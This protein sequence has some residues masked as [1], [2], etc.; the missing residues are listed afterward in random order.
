MTEPAGDIAAAAY[1]KLRDEVAAD[2]LHTRGTAHLP[3]DLGRAQF[4]L[5][6]EE[7][8]RRNSR[9]RTPRWRGLGKLDDK[10]DKWRNAKRTRARA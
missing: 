5:T 6:E 7:R 9:P 10:I 3:L 1:A 8:A 4:E 2:R